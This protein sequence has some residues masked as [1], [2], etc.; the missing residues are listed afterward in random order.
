MSRVIGKIGTLIGCLVFLAV[1]VLFLVLGIKAL[2]APKIEF[3]TTEGV[4]VEIEVLPSTTAEDTNNYQVYVDYVVDG[5]RYEHAKYGAYSSSMNIG[6]TVTVLYDPADPTH[7][8]A[9]GSEIVP[10]IIVAAGAIAVLLSVV[11]F[12]RRVLR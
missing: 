5:V 6:D 10:Y 8:E 9:E 11:F 12:F 4:V 1:G 7:I 2:S 3:A